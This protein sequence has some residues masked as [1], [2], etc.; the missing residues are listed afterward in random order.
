MV[1]DREPAIPVWIEVQRELIRL[2]IPHRPAHSLEIH[3]ENDDKTALIEP[4]I[5]RVAE[6]PHIGAQVLRI[7]DEEVAIVRGTGFFDQLDLSCNCETIKA[8]ATIMNST[9]IACPAT[10]FRSEPGAPSRSRRQLLIYSESMEEL[11]TLGIPSSLSV[12][13]TPSPHI[14][15]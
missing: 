1:L 4:L 15:E 9:A 10:I 13:L 12:E 3:V 2:T 7:Y 6:K 8:A 14:R 5:I 11:L